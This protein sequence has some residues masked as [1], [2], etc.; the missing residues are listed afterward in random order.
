VVLRNGEDEKT[1]IEGQVVVINGCDITGVFDLPQCAAMQKLHG[2]IAFLG[3]QDTRL[4]EKCRREQTEYFKKAAEE[5]MEIRRSGHL[6]TIEPDEN[7]K[8]WST[9]R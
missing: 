6:P 1:Y 8:G 5:L 2:D 4:P 3:Y 7:G 9:P